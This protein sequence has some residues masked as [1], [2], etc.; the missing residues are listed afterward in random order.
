MSF[1]VT[2]VLDEKE[3]REIY[4]LRYK[5]YCEE[6]GFERPEDHP[7]GLEK[8]VYDKSA[9]HFAAKD[10]TQ[11][12]V[13]T[14]RLILNSSEGFPIEKYC[15]LDINKDE[16]PR[17]SLAEISRLAISKEYRRRAEDRYIYGPDEERR[18]IGTFEHPHKLYHAY[19]R[20]E[21]KYKYGSFH[22]INKPFHDRRKKYE[23]V[24]SLYKAIYHES[25]KR[26]LT[27]WYAVMTKGLF[28]LLKRFGFNFQPIGEPVDYHGIRTPYLGEIKKIEQEVLNTNPELYE[29]FTKDLQIL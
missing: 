14:I 10:S 16:L 2:R 4:R 24:T 22:P 20:I 25:K 29:E 19:R 1:I 6:W 7:D 21:D 23:P 5:V 12:I 27:H 8:D 13:G 15:Q 17:E 18:I 11:K 3:L 9:V 26:G 28:L